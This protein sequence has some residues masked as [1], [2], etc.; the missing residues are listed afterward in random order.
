LFEDRRGRS[1]TI[2]GI[3]VFDSITNQFIELEIYISLGLITG[4]ST[5]KNSR[6]KIIADRVN[7]DRFFTQYWDSEIAQLKKILNSNELERLSENEVY[8]VTIDGT[9][10]YHIK[11]LEDG[12]FIGIDKKKNIYKI[13]HDPYEITKLDGELEDFL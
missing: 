10:Y 9:T 7:V 4:Y 5:P 3:S 2:K 8:E 6:I 1:V 12:D 13:T 11:D